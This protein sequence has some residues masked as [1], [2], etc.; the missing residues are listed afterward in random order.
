MLIVSIPMVDSNARL[1]KD[2]EATAKQSLT[3]T[4]APTA[5]TPVISTLNAKTLT[6]HIHVHVIMVS[7]VMVVLVVISMNVIPEMIIVTR[8]P[9]A[10]TL[11]VAM[12]VLVTMGLKA[13]ANHA[14]TSMNVSWIFLVMLMQLA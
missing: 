3:L 7:M 1:T 4:N 14:R 5:V 6:A 9:H 11:L 2:I 12:N 8:M 10:I 13:M